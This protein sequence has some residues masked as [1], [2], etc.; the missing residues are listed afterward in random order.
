VSGT[1]SKRPFLTCLDQPLGFRHA[2][3]EWTPSARDDLNRILDRP[4]ELLELVCNKLLKCRV[5]AGQVQTRRTTATAPT[6]EDLPDRQDLDSER[7]VPRGNVRALIVVLR[8]K[9][10]SIRCLAAGATMMP[11]LSASRSRVLS[12]S[13]RDG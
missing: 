3:S 2:E 8:V 5:G 1:A 10:L 4:V 6:I 12:V 13:K 7:S 9:S 11:R